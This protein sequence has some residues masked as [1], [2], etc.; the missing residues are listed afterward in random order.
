ML[1]N[2]IVWMTSLIHPCNEHRYEVFP[3]IIGM[4][5]NVSEKPGNN[6]PSTIPFILLEILFCAG[7]HDGRRGPP[8]PGVHDFPRV[9]PERNIRNYFGGRYNVFDETTPT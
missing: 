4:E 1:G 7:P 6:F 2:G 8:S 9:F 5:W 3:H